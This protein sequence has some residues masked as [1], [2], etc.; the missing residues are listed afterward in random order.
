MR[1]E[2]SLLST[3]KERLRRSSTGYACKILDGLT[4]EVSGGDRGLA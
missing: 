2:P 1:L 4:L 3:A